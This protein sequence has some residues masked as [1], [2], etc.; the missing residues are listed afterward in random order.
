[1]FALYRRNNPTPKAPR[2]RPQRFQPRLQPLEDRQ[3]PA[4]WVVSQGVDDM[5]LHGTLRYAIAQAADGDTI[6]IAPDVRTIDLTQGEL[7][8]DK[9]LTIEALQLPGQASARAKLIHTVSLSSDPDP[10]YMVVGASGGVMLRDLDFSSF[11]GTDPNLPDFDGQ[12][13]AFLNFGTLTLDNC[14]LHNN[15]VSSDGGAIANY[16]TLIL[17]GCSIHDNSAG[18]LLNPGSGG[19]VAN[20]GKMTVTD[21]VISNNT[22]YG[23]IRTILKHLPDGQP[24]FVVASVGGLGGGISNSLGSATLINTTVS[25]N[26]ALQ[27]AADLVLTVASG[28][29]I[30]NLGMM[31]VTG[32]HVFGNAA[33]IGGGIYNDVFNDVF[34]AL[35]VGTTDFST[36][37]GTLPPNTD[38]ST[39]GGTLP[40]NIDNIVGPYSD[41]GGNTFI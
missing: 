14:N 1:M 11:D 23:S 8:V 39:D 31:S 27:P 20:F 4:V 26:R 38:F 22:A 3:V 17:N 7:V 12:G 25:G 28:G 13:G 15:T 32:S 36:D 34:A 18:D 21:G 41:Q 37:G 24:V 9:T 5:N 10:R 2:A 40:P 35:S 6:R 16:G 19:G 29:G 30:F 33:R